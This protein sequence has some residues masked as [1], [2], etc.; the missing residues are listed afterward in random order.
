MSFDYEVFRKNIKFI[1]KSIKL[2]GYEVAIQAD[3]NYTTYCE[4]ENGTYTPTLKYV[5]NIANAL[6]RPIASLI[7]IDY[8]FEDT[9]KIANIIHLLQ[10]IT[11]K[12]LLNCIY[13]IILATKTREG[14][15]D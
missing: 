12:N 8:D 13:E 7:D 1:R 2:T 6:K 10:P 14:R 15:N 9:N 11:D 3:I 5:V 4:I